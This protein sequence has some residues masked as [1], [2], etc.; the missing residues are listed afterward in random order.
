MS[1]LDDENVVIQRISN[2][3]MSKIY[4]PNEQR[5]ELSPI[6]YAKW[7]NVYARVMTSYVKFFVKYWNENDV[8]ETN[9]LMIEE[10]ERV[11]IHGWTGLTAEEN[12]PIG[13]YVLSLDCPTSAADMKE[14]FKKVVKGDLEFRCRYPIDDTNAFQLIKTLNLVF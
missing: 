12:N 9:K 10:L 4:I 11:G 7:V 1:I 5:G 8:N 3:S 6:E 2:S 14:F 13:H